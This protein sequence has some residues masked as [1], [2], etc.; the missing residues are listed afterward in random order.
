MKTMKRNILIL[1]TALLSTVPLLAQYS[2]CYEAA[3]AEGKRLYDNGRYKE[4]KK[5][6][7]EARECPDPDAS[8]IDDWIKRCD[9]MVSGPSSSKADKYYDKGKDCLQ[10]HN[11]SD[12]LSWF[13]KAAELD[14]I[15]AKYEIGLMYFNELGMTKNDQEMVKWF[16]QAA[17]QGHADSQFVLGYMY[18]TGDG[19]SQD[20]SQAVNWYQKA[21]NQNHLSAMGDLGY[22]YMNGLVDGKQDFCKAFNLYK[23]AAGL[24]YDIAQYNMGTMYRDGLCVSTDIA[25]AKEWFEKAAGQGYPPACNALGALCL[26]EKDYSSAMKWFRNSADKDHYSGQYN[27]GYLYFEGLGVDKDWEEAVLWFRKAADQGMVEAQNNLGV[28]YRYGGHGVQ[29]NYSKAKEWFQIAADQGY[30]PAIKSLEDLEK[31]KPGLYI[32]TY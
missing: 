26:N 30:K 28:I 15:E 32:G 8:E 14:H 24:G 12:A 13:T 27:V 10:K 11:F 22:M 2:P 7:T 3:F 23:K 6:F 4:A 1:L 21:A 16:K 19:V 18:R 31:D 29:K 25:K 20:Y 17:E 5:Y 9:K